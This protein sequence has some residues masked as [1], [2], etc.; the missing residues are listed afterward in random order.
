M[1]KKYHGLIHVYQAQISLKKINLN[2]RLACEFFFQIFDFILKFT[3]NLRK[4]LNYLN[5][6]LK[7]NLKHEYAINTINT[8]LHCM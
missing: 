4:N 5:S 8:V 6:R 1:R 2:L 3:L 7:S